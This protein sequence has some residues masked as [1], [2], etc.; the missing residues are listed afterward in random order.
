MRPSNAAWVV[1]VFVGL[2]GCELNQGSPDAEATISETTTT[3]D[4]DG[5]TEDA[6]AT[7]PFTQDTTD[8]TPNTSSGPVLQ[9]DCS[10]VPGTWDLADC[11]GNQFVVEFVANGCGF[12]VSSNSPALVG[13]VGVAFQSGLTLTVP[14]AQVCHGFFDGSYLTGSCNPATDL[15][16]WFIATRR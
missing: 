14:P 12:Q 1:I 11:S 7:S 8:T 4:A 16:C 9:T 10:W 6:G 3:D 2:G 15:P 13:A 5:S